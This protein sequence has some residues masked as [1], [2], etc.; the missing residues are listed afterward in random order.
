LIRLLFPDPKL[1]GLVREIEK[2]IRDG[3]AQFENLPPEYADDAAAATGGVPINGIY[4][5][6]SAIKIRAS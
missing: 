4:R 5:S 2:A 1:A 6:G 3:Q